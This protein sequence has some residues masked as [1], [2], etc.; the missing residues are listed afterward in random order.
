[1]AESVKVLVRVRPFIKTEAKECKRS[2]HVTPGIIKVDPNPHEE[3]NP[4]KRY[5]TFHFDKVYGEASQQEEIYRESV[6][7]CINDLV[8]GFNSTVFAYGQTSSGKTHTMMGVSGHKTLQGIIPRAIDHLFRE[9]SSETESGNQFVLAVSYMEIYNEKVYDLLKRKKKRLSSRK[10]LE[11]RLNKT[12]FHVPTLTRHVVREKSSMF[13]LIE[14]G[15]KNR[16]VALSS[17]NSES[18]R[19]HSIFTIY[20]ERISETGGGETVVSAKLNIVDLAG[21]EKFQVKGDD[22]LK[23]E[24]AAI[25]QSLNSLGNVIAALSSEE[26]KW[27][28]YRD[29]ALTM[30][31]KDSLG[32][33]SKTLMLANINPCDRNVFETLSTLR[34]ASRAK[35]IQNI[36][37]K[38]VNPKDGILLKLQEEIK[39]L[40]KLL[41]EKDSLIKASKDTGMKGEADDMK[42]EVL[43]LRKRMDTVIGTI[44]MGGSAESQVN[45]SKDASNK[46]RISLSA[47]KAFLG[48]EDST[49]TKQE[50]EAL[51]EETAEKLKRAAEREKEIL[52]ALE[53]AKEKESTQKKKLKM[54]RRRLNRVTGSMLKI[55][56][57]EY[58]KMQEEYNQLE[59]EGEDGGPSIDLGNAMI[60]AP[61]DQRQPTLNHEKTEAQIVAEE[62]LA[63]V[64][65]ELEEKKKEIKE[66]HHQM[67]LDQFKAIEAIREWAAEKESEYRH[68]TEEL[69]K[70][71]DKIILEAKRKENVLNRKVKNAQRHADHLQKKNLILKMG[72]RKSVYMTMSLNKRLEI[73]G[74]TGI[75][76]WL[77]K[78]GKYNPAFRKRYCRLRAGMDEGEDQLALTYY[79]DK[80]SL[81]KGEVIITIKTKITKGKRDS[82]NH[83]EF[84]IHTP[85]RRFVFAAETEE[86][87]N[88]WHK[89]CLCLQQE[90]NTRAKYK[91]SNLDNPSG[92]D[93]SYFSKI[94]QSGEFHIRLNK[95]GDLK[96][97]PKSHSSRSKLSP[98]PSLRRVPSG[99]ILE[100]HLGTGRSKTPTSQNRLSRSF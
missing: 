70:E 82:K 59:K 41:E 23:K 10:P 40:R 6:S 87:R 96:I 76:G 43:L 19:S 92:R 85:R 13:G 53:R 51:K 20:L 9:I 86:M 67:D 36:V 27:V 71:K 22:K 1:M 26:K 45:T 54:L 99:S 84:H 49:T 98:R 60:V 63:N 62:A 25:N 24:N 95:R 37:T 58:Q 72:P 89:A 69:K 39:I 80:K 31:L 65:A 73:M 2:I 64:A 16:N 97:S 100:A 14:L 68:M 11:I 35:R 38:N 8:K 47:E 15:S 90:H 93:S 57:D 55:N 7:A 28:P 34:Y 46:R 18:S 75:S 42:K 3:S 29:S 44:M 94:S 12:G 17:Q 33:N 50:V 61:E 30:L 52:Q 4:T 21:S 74:F 83:F 81:P 77:I 32:G 66:L 79:K 56:P 88:N 5:K 48:E 78:R 91:K